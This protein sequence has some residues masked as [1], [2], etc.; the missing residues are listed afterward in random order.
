MIELKPCPFCGFEASLKHTANIVGIQSSYV[1]CE[2]C[3]SR[4]M[5]I[6]ASVEYCADEKAIEFW[7]GRADE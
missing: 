6:A 1:E 3:K 4:T 7:N 5:P 2:N